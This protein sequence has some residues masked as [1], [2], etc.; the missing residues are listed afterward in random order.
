MNNTKNYF[1]LLLFAG[2]FLLSC[3]TARKTE[4]I[5]KNAPPSSEVFKKGEQSFD[6]HCSKCHPNG[7][8]GLGPALNNKQLV[9]RF[10]IRFQV[11]NG[12]GKMPAFSDEKIPSEELDAILDYLGEIE[13]R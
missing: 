8:A 11:R 5:V 4:P 1:L 2:T 13:D 7:E 10:L 12:L 3:G 6:K 9:P